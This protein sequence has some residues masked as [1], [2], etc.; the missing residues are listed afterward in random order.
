VLYFTQRIRRR[1]KKI[2]WW[3]SAC[4]SVEHHSGCNNA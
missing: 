2:M 1:G 3:K 4:P